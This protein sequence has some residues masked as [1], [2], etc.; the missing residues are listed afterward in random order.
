MVA[1]FSYKNLTAAD[2]IRLLLLHPRAASNDD[3][4]RCTL[5]HTTL[6]ECENDLTFQYIALS[7]VWGDETDQKTIVVDGAGF[8]VTANLFR[9]LHSIRHE[10]KELPLWV[11]A[12]CINQKNMKERGQQV[13]F[14]GS[15]Y[16]AARNTIIYLG[17]SDTESDRAIQALNDAA[18]SP[19]DIVDDESIRECI[20]SS[21]L[22]RTWFTRVWVLQELALSQNPIIQIGQSRVRWGRLPSFLFALK[23]TY[24]HVQ[25]VAIP[26]SPTKDIDAEQLMIDMQEAREKIQISNISVNKKSIEKHQTLLGFI[27]SR[28]GLGAKD[29]RDIIFAHIGMVNHISGDHVD[30]RAR[31]RATTQLSA[32]MTKSDV[33]SVAKAGPIESFSL[34][35]S[36]DWNEQDISIDYEK[37]AAEVYNNFACQAI[38]HSRDLSITAHIRDTYPQTR[39]PGLA[40]W[41]P[42]WTQRRLQQ[43]VPLRG[44]QIEDHFKQ[45]HAFVCENSILGVLACSVARIKEISEV[46]DFRDK[47]FP[48]TYAKPDGLFSPGS[49]PNYQKAIFFYRNIHESWQK[50]LD[51]KVLPP[52]SE[53]KLNDYH[54]SGDQ[55]ETSQWDDFKMTRILWAMDAITD[56]TH[57]I[58]PY[59]FPGSPSLGHLS[60]GDYLVRC[61]VDQRNDTIVRGRRVALLDNGLNAL[62]PASA[63]KG[64]I[65]SK[66]NIHQSLIILRHHEDT[67]GATYESILRSKIRPPLEMEKFNPSYSS[68]GSSSYGWEHRQI[69]LCHYQFVGECLLDNHQLNQQSL[70]NW[71]RLLKVAIEIAALH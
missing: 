50:R 69:P 53:R 45:D 68:S 26:D 29:P 66:I 36:G 8:H 40:S 65:V 14:M 20:K 16:A 7:Y 34:P 56:N 54:L 2:S 12:L 25:V 42:D 59:G 9:A 46:I 70:L 6:S 32:T 58:D 47:S 71:D 43:L 62:V 19:D 61:S 5:Q 24:A 48:R 49:D 64:D 13:R 57:S 39:L 27:Q 23:D 18:D 21:I 67:N 15:I 10:S 63:Q 22:S 33:T 38:E 55:S 28:S 31:S 37:T 51:S 60:I 1:E 35:D 41:A 3:E 11:D 30:F 4:I 17:E 44:R 52:L